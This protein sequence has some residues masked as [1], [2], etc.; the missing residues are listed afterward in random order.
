MFMLE[1]P[2]RPGEGG[3]FFADGGEGKGGADVRVS[4]VIVRKETVVAPPAGAWQYLIALVLLAVTAGA[5]LELG[6]ATQISKIPPDVLRYFTAPPEQQGDPPALEA[7]T[8]FVRDALPSAYGVLGVQL[9]HELA[10]WLVAKQRNV[11]LGIPFLIPNITIGTFGSITQFRSPCPDL[12]TK[13]DVAVA[14]PVAGGALS[15]AM[16]AAGLALTSAAS[17]APAAADPMSVGIHSLAA[18]G[19]VQVPSLLF[20]GS[21]LLGVA[22]RAAL[23]PDLLHAAM[24]PVHPLL[25]TGWC[26]LTASALNLLPLGSLDGGRAMQAAYGRSSTTWASTITYILLALGLL[27]GTLSLPFG[28]YV[29]ILQVLS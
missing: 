21:L 7:L 11:R 18:E 20:Q 6:L 1:E 10:H 2:Q 8:P 16:F 25:I 26:G 27:G 23:G 15:F 28:L 17:S 24:V 14:G 9:F 3:S 22:S 4:F 19:V 13:F 12:K 5:C 29:L